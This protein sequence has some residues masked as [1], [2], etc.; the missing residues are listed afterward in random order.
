MSHRVGLG[1]HRIV[2]ESDV[3]VRSA[4]YSVVVDIVDSKLQFAKSFCAD[5]TYKPS[6]PKEGETRVQG[7]ERNAQELIASEAS[8]DDIRSKGGFD[9]VLECTGAEPCVQMGLFAAKKRSRF[10]QIGMGASPLSL[11]THRIGIYV[12]DSLKAVQLVLVSDRSFDVPRPRSFCHGSSHRRSRWWDPSA[13]AQAST[14][15]PLTLWLQERSTSAASS[16]TATLSR[17]PSWHSRQPRRAQVKVS[18][19]E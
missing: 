8:S 3:C 7:S 19:R 13:T 9:L 17:T 11:P 6:M 15:P 1:A 18:W 16:P 12:S 4:F 14:G 10:V 5:A 2:P